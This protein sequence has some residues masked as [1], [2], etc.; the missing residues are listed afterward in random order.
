MAENRR[1]LRTA[2]RVL[3][4]SFPSHRR[5]LLPLEWWLPRLEGQYVHTH[6]LLT[7]SHPSSPLSPSCQPL[8]HS[9]LD[10]VQIDSIR[11]TDRLS[12]ERAKMC[13]SVLSTAHP[14]YPFVLISNRDEFINRP[15]LNANWWDPPHEQVLGGRDT[16]RKERGTWLGITKQGRIAILTNFREEGIEVNKDKSRGA[17]TN[18]Y[19]CVDPESNETEE[20]YVKRL[21][22]DVGI[23]DVGGFTLIFGKLRK[24]KHIQDENS[25]RTPYPSSSSAVSRLNMLRDHQPPDY[26]TKVNT[27]LKPR[28]WTQD[29]LRI[30]S[31]RTDSAASLKRVADSTGNTHGLSNS[32]WGDVTWPKVIHGEIQLAQI[33]KMDV[34]KGGDEANFIRGLFGVLS[35][36][37]LPK[38]KETENWDE[39]VRHMR[40]SILIPPAKGEQAQQMA[41]YIPHATSTSDS[42]NSSAS[43]AE[44]AYGTSKQTVIL[45]DKQGHVI[46]IE[47]SLYN[48][49][50]V[51]IP[52]NQRD[53][54]F[55]F[56]IEGWSEAST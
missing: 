10:L 45:V 40:D 56:D 55:E 38:R 29:G 48:S 14:D 39:Y 1:G 30:I 37:H 15:T 46:Y 41:G 47:R 12:R 16:Q 13:I 42:T 44:T 7:I 6:D 51:P 49:R 33:I 52:E 2:D 34:M 5:R 50:G 24:P 3:L 11:R 31:N 54:R 43:V 20:E 26:V 25:V 27:V 28:P 18:S 21:L 53:Q 35:I 8:F 32:H 36:D 23:H 22:D 9:D 4:M 19:L 17:I